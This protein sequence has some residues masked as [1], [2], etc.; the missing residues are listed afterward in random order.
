MPSAHHTF[1]PP[2]DPFQCLARD[3]RA[4]VHSATPQPHNQLPLGA[5]RRISLRSQRHAAVAQSAAV[6]QAVAHI[7]FAPH[8]GTACSS[9]TCDFAK[10]RAS[11]C[12]TAAACPVATPGSSSGR[13]ASPGGGSS[14]A[15]RLPL[16][17]WT[18]IEQAQTSAASNVTTADGR[19]EQDFHSWM[20]G[21]WTAAVQVHHFADS[22]LCLP[23][24]HTGTAAAGATCL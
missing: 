14:R 8:Q 20:A 1:S 23:H 10:P 17:C 2:F 18:R 11:A 12:D 9:A 22:M 13:F 24:T 21:G 16:T 5:R 4:T 7:G 6:A 19:V 3:A 15:Y